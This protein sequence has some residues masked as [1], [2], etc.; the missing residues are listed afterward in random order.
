MTAFVM[1]TI[2]VLGSL[3]L[4]I[5]YSLTLTLY[6]ELSEE[7]K[8]QST[9]PFNA[10]IIRVNRNDVNLKLNKFHFKEHEL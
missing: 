3:G 10:D 8:Q 6:P 1:T 4:P 2:K 5:I 7:N 9:L